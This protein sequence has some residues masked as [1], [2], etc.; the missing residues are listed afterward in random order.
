MMQSFWRVAG[1]FIGAGMITAAVSGQDRGEAVGKGIAR[2]HAAYFTDADRTPSYALMHDVPATGAL[3]A[4][5]KIRPVFSKAQDGRHAVRIELEP[6]TSLYGTGEVAGSLERT[7]RSVTLWNYDAFGYTPDYPSLYQSH[8]WVLAVRA[9][10]TAFGVLADTT[11]RAEVRLDGA[12][13]FFGE[14]APYPVFIIDRESP[15]EV[16][17]GLAELIGTMPLPPLWAIGYHQCRYS[18]NP[19]AR[20]REVADEFRKRKI[21]CDVI[22]FDIDYM[23]EYR[24]FTVDAKQF[25]DLKKLNTDLGAMGF[26]RIFM[27]DPGIKMEKGY[28]VYDDAMK[29]DV[30]VRTASGEVFQGAVWPGMCI[31]P[32]YTRPEVRDWWAG[33]FKD[34]MAQGVSGVWNDMNEPA[35]FGTP[36]K[37]MPEDNVHKGGTET[38][39]VV[40]PGP[41][42]R[43]HNVYGMM[44]AKGTFDGIAAAVP[45]KRPFVLTRAGYIGSQRYAATW[46][47]DN[48]ATWNDLE[49]SIPM[50]INLGLSGQ[51]FAGPDIG[52]FNGNG[53][54]DKAERATLFSRWMGIG[55]LL[56]FS[57]GHTAKGNIDKEPWA[58][59]PEAEVTCRQALERR[60]RLLPYYYT[61]FYE[62]HKTGLPVVRPAFFADPRDQAL[63]AEDDC[64][65]IGDDVLVVPQLMPDNSRVMIEPKGDWR[66]FELVG[67]GANPDLP[68]LKIRAGSIVPLGPV[69]QYTGEKPLDPLTLLIALDETNT[70]NGFLYEDAGDGFGYQQGQFRRTHYT[71]KLD[72]NTLTLSIAKTEGQ[73]PRPKR[74]IV[75]QVVLPGGKIAEG[76]GADGGNI[77]FDIK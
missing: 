44:M 63:R 67:E 8:P 23:N 64:F 61:L 66:P 40:K 6:G 24:V 54:R 7:G 4:D 38:F 20:V 41:H 33:L 17:K 1:A 2:F 57:R 72:R 19:D 28:S 42:L 3:P 26:E 62:A 65:L 60:Y 70:A 75:V 34:F 25:P 69:M 11:W 21:P 56:G 43:F 14:G 73:L 16:I 47:G 39:G 22:W 10:G 55:S 36:T 45:G 74:D 13:E 15:Q 48:S 46:T 27:I 37:T 12:I 58:F 59:G 68:K 76:K 30:A 9:D 49:Q 52:G 77:R 35:V 50:A 51:P 53:P 5:F 71:A 31:F 18:Y 29:N 32:D